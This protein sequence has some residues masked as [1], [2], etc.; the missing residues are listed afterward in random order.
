M[1]IYLDYA[2]ST[3][4]DHRVAEK[5]HQIMLDKELCANPASLH[6][7]G[8]KARSLIELAREQVADAIAAQ[9]KEII[10]TSGA[11]ESNNLAIK[12]VANLYVNRGKHII[13]AKTEHKSVLD[14]CL[15]LEKQGYQVTYLSP[16]SNG[17]IELAD[18]ENAIKPETILVSIM[19]VNNETGVI[20]DIASIAHL[21][22]QRG[23]LFHVDAAQSIGKLGINTQDIPVDLISLSAHKVYGPKGIGALY[24]RRKPRVR[25]EPLLHGGG[26]EQGMR[27]GTLATH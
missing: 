9:A 11:T 14:V 18:I 5:M 13:T 2:A 22:Q 6:P 19:H 4:I 17:K 12:G 3:P 15:Y 8:M 21:T 26:H 16:Q 7:P 27:S 25:V 24:L 1:P 20:Q 23:I 10:W